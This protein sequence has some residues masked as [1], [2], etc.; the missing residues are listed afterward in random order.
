MFNLCLTQKC[1]FVKN[2]NMASSKIL[3]YKS[4]QKSDGRYPIVIRVI[5]DRRPK[6]IYIDWVFEK[7]WNEDTRQVKSSHPNSKRL[8]NL[9]L[10][11]LAEASDLI[12][13]S[14]S[15]KKDFTSGQITRMMKGKRKETT[16]F[17]LAG[18][19]ISDL[20][21]TGKHNRANTDEPR[22]NV[23]K[24]FLGGVDIDFSEIDAP[25]LKRLSVYMIGKREVTERTVMNYY[26]LIR[27]LFNRAISEGIVEQKYYP[28]GKGKIRIRVQNTIKIGLDEEEIKKIEGLDLEE[29]ST[30]WH[31]RNVF[32]FSFYFAGMRISDVL[33]T[34]WSD[35]Q[36][37]RFYY[38]MGKNNKADSLLVPDKIMGIIKHYKTDET[39]SDD[40][41]FPE[42][43]KANLKD[44]EDVFRKIK[45]AIRKFN[46]N[47]ETIAGLATINKKLTNHIARHS[48]GNIAGDK[49]SPQMLQ[50][51]YRHS[52]LTTTIGYQGNF[53][54]K[55]A[56]EALSSV[57][58]FK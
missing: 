48:F 46:D 1:I 53:I 9:I 24:E 2:I 34:K 28:F 7:D 8:N 47:L 14:E 13:E 6:Y 42:L 16:F 18:E 10:K 50:K 37:D 55:N 31:T 29:G 36:N 57:I 26:I 43:K 12:L 38:T 39:S 33:R 32:L 52:S 22:L 3:L 30:I 27:T 41:I 5:K 35:I 15:Q 56:D 17:K 49:V 54:H 40:F 23:F 45:T 51:L 4:K 19:Y 21:K 44:S 20:R 11:K 25:L 58:S